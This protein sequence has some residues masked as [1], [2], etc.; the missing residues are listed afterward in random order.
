MT[1]N[2]PPSAPP[3][4]SSGTTIPTLSISATI[5]ETT[6][7]KMDEVIASSQGGPAKRVR[8][9]KATRPSD[10]RLQ[11]VAKFFVRAVHPY[12]DIGSALHYGPDRHWGHRVVVDPSNTVVTPPS[13]LARQDAFVQ[14]FDLMFSV[15]P[16][17]VD[18]IKCFYLA[19][20][21]SPEL[22]NQL[23]A[24]MRKA[25]TSARTNDTGS[26][27]HCLN[28]VLPSPW[29]QA[30]LPAILKQESKSNR[31]VTHP[32]LRY[33]ILGWEHRMKLPPLVLPSSD[34]ERV[35]TVSTDDSDESSSTD[36]IPP[37]P[38]P[39]NP[40]LEKLAAGKVDLDASDFP[41]FLWEFDSYD[42]DNFDDGLL[43]GELVLRVLRHIWTAPS[44]AYMGL[45]NGIPAVCN[46]RLHEYFKITPP[47]IGYA[48]AQARTMI[49][50]T[51]WTSR[52]GSYS[53]EDLFD[54]IVQLLSDPED[55]WVT[56]TLNWFQR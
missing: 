41:S 45:D 4:A 55:P 39:R 46:A 32:I 42:P 6:K 43:R 52:D 50:T 22:W 47:M 33:F 49:A 13:E 19:I 34:D 10:Q 24:K 23:V 37:P 1:S 40:F 29:K 38:P 11:S 56:E 36:V 14:A 3:S 9:P 44:S 5:P 21:E 20:P 18:V 51:D 26:L 2:A 8:G 27:K 7:R 53:Y 54:A 12:M 16:D 48:V 31:G 25:A 30:L 17:L 28:Y 35:S 15:A